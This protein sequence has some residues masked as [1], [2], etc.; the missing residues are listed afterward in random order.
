MKHLEPNIVFLQISDQCP[1]E[2][3]DDKIIFKCSQHCA[4]EASRSLP[5]SHLFPSPSPNRARDF[6]FRAGTRLFLFSRGRA[7]RAVGTGR[8]IACLVIE[9]QRSFLRVHPVAGP[10]L[11]YLNWSDAGAARDCEHTR[12]AR[13]H[14]KAKPRAACSPAVPVSVQPDNSLL[15]DPMFLPEDRSLGGRALRLAKRNNFLRA[16][17]PPRA[18]SVRPG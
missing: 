3:D 9:K 4:T 5:R 8:I 6:V 17:A 7:R 13:K 16:G 11:P 10:S 14:R 2:C 15:A 18:P 1:N 12:I